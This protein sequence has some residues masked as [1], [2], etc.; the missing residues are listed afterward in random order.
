MNK[1]F[2]SAILCG[3]MLVTAIGTFV[4]CKDY[5]DDIDDLQSQIDNLST[6]SSTLTSNLSSVQ[7]T[8]ESQ[9]SSTQ[10]TLQSQITSAQSALQ[11]AINDKA[12]AS[13]LSTLAGNVSTLEQNLAAQTSTL[14]TQ[15]TAAQT[16]IEALQAAGSNEEALQEAVDAANAT[17]AALTGA[18]STDAETV[19]AA[20]ANLKIQLDAVIA[21]QAAVEA[22]DYQAQIDELKQYISGD[23][24]DDSTSLT[25]QIE[26]VKTQLEEAIAAN[27]T[28]ITTLQDQIQKIS[29]ALIEINPNLDALTILVKNGVTSIELVYSYTDQ[30]TYGTDLYITVATQQANKFEDNNL[31][32]IT[33]AN[34]ITF[35]AGNLY[36]V[37]A[38]L[39]VR[40]SP[41]NAELTPDMIQFV[42]SQGGTLDGIVEVT[43][44]EKYNTLL[45]KATA[46]T[47]LWTVY[48]QLVDQTTEK[49]MEAVT[50]TKVNN[51]TKNILFAVQVN[52]TPDSDETRYATSSYDL[53]MIWKPYVEAHDLFYFVG[54]YNVSKLVNRY[55]NNGA[56]PSLPYTDATNEITYIEKAWAD[57]IKNYPTPAVEPIIVYN[58]DGTINTSKSNV[59]QADGTGTSTTVPRNT[60]SDDRSTS[61]Y[62]LYPAVQGEAFTIALTTSGDDSKVTAPDN[63]RAIYVTL[64]MQENA[65]ESAPSEWN[66]WNSYSYTGLNTVVEG[67]KTSITINNA[68]GVINDIIGFRVYAVNYDG[69]LVDPDGK[70]FYVAVGDVA[71]NWNAKAT[72]IVPEYETTLT[73]P[74]D[75]VAVSLTTLTGIDHATWVTDKVGGSTNAFTAHFYNASAKSD[76]FTTD[77]TTST[78]LTA[79]F[80]KVT[81]VYTTINSS[82]A[83]SDFTDDKAY[84]GTLTYYD[85]YDHV[86]ASIK[87]TLTK[88]LPSGMPVGFSPKTSQIVNGVYYCYLVPD[89]WTVDA[90]GTNATVG[91]MPMSHV[92]NFGDEVDAY[93]FT[94]ANSAY[95]G[96]S[97]TKVEITGET[98]TLEIAAFDLIDNTTKRATTVTYNYGNIS[99]TS[100]NNPWKKTYTFNTIYECVYNDTYSW[101]WAT[102]TDLG[103][104]VTKG[105]DGSVTKVVDAQGN[106][107][108]DSYPYYSTELTY[109]EDVVAGTD[110]VGSYFDA[111][112]WGTSKWDG[113]YS[114]FLSEPY[115]SSLYITDAILT[116]DANP[117]VDNE[118]FQPEVSGGHITGFTATQVTSDTNPTAAIP[119][120]L[121]IKATDMYGHELTLTFPM[122]VIRR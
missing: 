82:L 73:T 89:A 31:D 58:N 85:Q 28:D 34:Q 4:S 98:S 81:G 108:T 3:A 105:N 87:V 92:F 35:T 26:A 16:A 67:T 77:Q 72:T 122:T 8:L 41:V 17:L 97:L 49:E 62:V 39:V 47:G 119:S 63:I 91:T 111:Y 88:T 64:D 86:L 45:T 118:Y 84:T 24:S 93:T 2:L 40:V 44:V 21:F 100:G 65:I 56:N 30:E 71:T 46:A 83:W 53:T 9:L 75:T 116:S 43:K 32:N 22:A 110:F 15:I 5:D 23:D 18:A 74:S 37:P 101:A 94:F 78:A 117:S 52:N 109:G 68:N 13:E 12:D 112:I 106:V 57:S 48:V 59:V 20:A 27:T 120:T 10:S 103:L 113:L 69:T 19:A 14:T 51:V 36:Q 95:S 54:D 11:S 115:E 76:V 107:V 29:D 121:T 42:N 7:S 79:T 55:A 1:K 61:D 70:A 80:T 50:Q 90:N 96:S 102:D 99:S 66:A 6:S 38:Q 25:E 114:A 33:I 104:T 60:V